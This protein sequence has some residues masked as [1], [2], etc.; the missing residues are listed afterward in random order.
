MIYWTYSRSEAARPP[1]GLI[2]FLGVVLAIMVVMVRGWF[3]YTAAA[4][5]VLDMIATTPRVVARER[6][7][8]QMHSLR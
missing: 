8:K 1:Y 3:G 5:I 7:E 4:L 2:M 6:A